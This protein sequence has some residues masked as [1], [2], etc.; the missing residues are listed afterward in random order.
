MVIASGG[1]GGGSVYGEEL[2]EYRADYS[3]RARDGNP[4]LQWNPFGY[5]TARV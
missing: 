5:L 3:G 1:G 2:R 4:P